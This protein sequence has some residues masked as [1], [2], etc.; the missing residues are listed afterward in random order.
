MA[1]VLSGLPIPEILKEA[2]EATIA[3]E[4]SPTIRRSEALGVQ[5]GTCAAV[6]VG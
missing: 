3:V 5:T 1:L 2:C 6:V 4:S